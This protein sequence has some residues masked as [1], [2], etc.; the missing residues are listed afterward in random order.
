MS[1]GNEPLLHREPLRPLHTI[2]RDRLHELGKRAEELGALALFHIPGTDT[3]QIYN[4]YPTVVLVESRLVPAGGPMPLSG[5]IA[6]P[7]IDVV[8]GRLRAK[9]RG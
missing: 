4:P 9:A 7:R 3:V 2:D 1:E 6:V 5:T 8:L